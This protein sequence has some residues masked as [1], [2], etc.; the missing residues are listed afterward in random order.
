MI[1]KSMHEIKAKYGAIT[2]DNVIEYAKNPDSPIHNLFEWDN[3]KAA[4]NWRVWQA[5]KMIAECTITVETG[6]VRE[7]HNVFVADDLDNEDVGKRQYVSFTEIVT[8]DSLKNQMLQNAKNDAEIYKKKY[9]TIE[10]CA[11]II[12]AI[13]DSFD[14]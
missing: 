8:D 6:T 11:K 5:R 1:S 2:P 14:G 4:Y 10:A 9:G 12:S 3:D 7:F 13:N